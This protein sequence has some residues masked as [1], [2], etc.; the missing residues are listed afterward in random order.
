[1]CELPSLQSKA[2]ISTYT[3]DPILS[4]TQGHCSIDL[5]LSLLH[6]QLPPLYWTI[7]II[8]ILFLAL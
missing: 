5:P 2:I 7:L 4:T 3:L 1:M 8:N 6:H